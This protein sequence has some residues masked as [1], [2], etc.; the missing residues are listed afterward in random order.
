MATRALPGFLAVYRSNHQDTLSAAWLG[1]AAARLCRAALAAPVESRRR[2][3][4]RE[5]ARVLRVPR[6]D[7][8]AQLPEDH[9]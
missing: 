4:E 8:P 2:R 9:A 6:E 3:A 7:L 5:I 1:N